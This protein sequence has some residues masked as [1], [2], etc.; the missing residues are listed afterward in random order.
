MR[1][2]TCGECGVTGGVQS[3]YTLN[4]TTYCEPCVWKASKQAKDAGSPGEYT[5]L[6]DHTLCNRCGTD[7]GN[8]DLPMF[9]K[10]RLCSTCAPSVTNWPYPNWLKL[11]L[12]GTLA[13]L[14]VAL[15]QGRRY[16]QAGK[17][18]YIGEYL[19]EQKR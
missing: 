9:G 11:A 7:N 1:Q 6:E 10:L 17:D 3:F 4:G 15:Y 5:A 19:V 2:G 16:F 8:I 14:L 18:M 12:G 13:L